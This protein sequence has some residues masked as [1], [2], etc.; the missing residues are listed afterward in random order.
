MEKY[1]PTK[2]KPNL[3]WLEEMVKLMD[4]KF[5][6]P[7]T[8]FRFGVDPVLGLLPGIGDLASF[9]ISGSLVL[10]M[11][12]FGVSRKVVA[13]MLLNIFLDATIGSIP[14]IG[15]IFDFYYK[16]NTRN[17]NLLREHYYENKHQGGSSGIIALVGLI[18]L[19]LIILLFWALWEFVEWILTYL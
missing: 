1:G 4:S 17:I 13:L 16:A 19:I 11:L 5:R 15:H 12:R 18:L 7:G 6:I 10:Y 3:F 8:S 9:A 14:I 2:E